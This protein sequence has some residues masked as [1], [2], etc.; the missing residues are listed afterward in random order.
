MKLYV[1][2]R[3]RGDIWTLLIEIKSGFITICSNNAV[4]IDLGPHLHANIIYSI[5]HIQI[6]LYLHKYLLKPLFFCI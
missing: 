5:D 4:I 3:L 6:K 1:K 2:Q